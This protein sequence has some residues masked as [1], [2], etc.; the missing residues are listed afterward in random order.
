MRAGVRPASISCRPTRYRHPSCCGPYAPLK[1]DQSHRQDVRGF[2]HSATIGLLEARQTC[3]TRLRIGPVRFMENAT[4]LFVSGTRRLLPLCFVHLMSWQRVNKSRK[5]A[6]P[7]KGLGIIYSQNLCC[8]DDRSAT[9]SS[10][11]L[12]ANSSSLRM[13]WCPPRH[14]HT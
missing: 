8:A 6:S 9:N 10:D 5:R 12:A 11:E 13:R 3:H 14:I 7:S 2:L 4:A 1:S